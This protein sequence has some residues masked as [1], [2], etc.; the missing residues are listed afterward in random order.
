M[1]NTMADPPP[2]LY[3]PLHADEETFTRMVIAGLSERA[4]IGEKR[5]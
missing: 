5:K 4:T 3:M 1:P 2:G